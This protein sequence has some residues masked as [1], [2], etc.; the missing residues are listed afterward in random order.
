MPQKRALKIEPA[1][2]EVAL[3]FFWFKGCYR[4]QRW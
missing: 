2:T 4:Y 3:L 1:D